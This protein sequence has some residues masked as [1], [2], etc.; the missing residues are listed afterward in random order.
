MHLQRYLLALLLF[1]AWPTQAAVIYKWTDAQGLVH[2]ADQPVPGA[3]KIL[4]NTDSMNTMQAQT[5]AAAPA[6]AVT[7]SPAAVINYSTF[8]ISSPTPE[9]SF[10]NEPI[11]VRLHLEPSLQPAHTLNWYLNGKLLDGHTDAISF[12]MAELPRGAYTLVA[13]IAD[14]ATA[15]SVSS[16]AVTFYAHQPSKLMPHHKAP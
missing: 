7:P 12:T 2:Y 16:G 4:T 3:Q 10:F 9:Q 1:A 8:S 14:P 6:S 13:T 15:Q 11:A 5:S